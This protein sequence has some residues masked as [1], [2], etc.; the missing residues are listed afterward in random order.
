VAGRTVASVSVAEH[1]A[2]PAFV[3]DSD[4]ACRVE[5]CSTL[6]LVWPEQI[7]A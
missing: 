2:V 5:R 6:E 4:W 3:C 7:I 1:L